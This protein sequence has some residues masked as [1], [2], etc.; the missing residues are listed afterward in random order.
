MVNDMV[1]KY[2]QA[3]LTLPEQRTCCFNTPMYQ[4]FF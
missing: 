3:L 1:V 2:V 4:E